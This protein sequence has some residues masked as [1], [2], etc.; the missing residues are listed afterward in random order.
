MLRSHIASTLEA[1]YQTSQSIH[2]LSLSLPSISRV[3]SLTM[4]SVQLFLSLSDTL[5][6]FYEANATMFFDLFWYRN[7]YGGESDYEMRE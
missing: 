1:V 7:Y 2:V 5:C 4:Y 3:F 6:L